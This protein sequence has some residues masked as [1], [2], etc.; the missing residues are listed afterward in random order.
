MADGGEYPKNI[1]STQELKRE[2][3]E[4]N[5]EDFNK[6]TIWGQT[7]QYVVYILFISYTLLCCWSFCMRYL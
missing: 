6:P 5:Q 1:F 2:W 7:L 3:F 4:E